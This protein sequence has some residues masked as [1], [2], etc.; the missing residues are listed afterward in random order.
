MAVRTVVKMGNKQL[1]TPSKTVENWLDCP[2]EI[3]TIIQDMQE[4][5]YAEGGVGI[6]A[7][8]IGCNLRIIMF[9]LSENKR[10]PQEKAIPFTVLI[11]PTIKII[12][13]TLVDGWEACLS[14][15][16]LRGLV[17]RYDEIE[18][19]GYDITGNKIIRHAT[20]FHARALQHECDH[21]DGILY[22]QRLKDLRYFG[23]EDELL[24]NKS[25]C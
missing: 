10:Y 8:Q 18:Y 5:M 9:G 3:I 20:G 11:N 2:N 4:T 21:L 19:S 25:N 15:P 24:H 13:S 14:I 1:S 6:A 16:G 22:P 7:P 17:A 12:G 23:F